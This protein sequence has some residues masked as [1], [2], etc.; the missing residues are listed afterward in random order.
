MKQE[1]RP[2]PMIL[3]YDIS[4]GVKKKPM[5]F[6]TLVLLFR[7]VS[8]YPFRQPFSVSIHAVSK[9]INSSEEIISGEEA[10][11]GNQLFISHE[12]SS[13]TN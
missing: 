10:L 1:A 5:E 4:Q 8:L 7:Q 11:F 3:K 12:A 2:I 6:S 9:W 13:A